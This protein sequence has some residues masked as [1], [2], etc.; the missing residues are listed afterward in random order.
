[1]KER[2]IAWVLGMAVR[3]LRR[4]AVS[5]DRVWSVC[6]CFAPKAKWDSRLSPIDNSSSRDQDFI[7]RVLFDQTEVDCAQ[8][9]CARSEGFSP[10]STWVLASDSS[11][12]AAGQPI[13]ASKTSSTKRAIAISLRSVARRRP[14]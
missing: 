8:F 5:C 1:M 6:S 13:M 9:G 10:C 3:V 4:L 12:E 7:H 11:E 14:G 2:Q